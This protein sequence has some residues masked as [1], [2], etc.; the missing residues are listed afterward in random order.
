M[1]IRIC[2]LA[3]GSEG[4][5]LIAEFDDFRLLI[6]CGI[7]KKALWDSL[8]A[9]AVDPASLKGLLLTHEHID[10]CRGLLPVLKHTDCPVFAS[11]GSFEGLARHGFFERLPKD[12]F[13]LFKGGDTFPLGPLKVRTIP[14]SHDSLEPVAFRL[15]TEEFSFA[16]VTDLGCY[17][18]ALIQELRG[19]QAL[20]L[21][22][23]HNRRML[24]AGPYP[25]SL[26]QRIDGTKGHL[27]NED[28]GQLLKALYHPGLEQVLLAHLSKT[29]NYPPLALETVSEALRGIPE[30]NGRLRLSIAP[31]QGCSEIICQ[32]TQ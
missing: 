12:R 3:S 13:I 2:T 32:S 31:Y 11:R 17:D 21:E 1:K 15:D 26:K 19:L 22:A 10:H 27:S 9:L 5:A 20:V 18:E 23:N 6:D 4:N 29:N 14:L 24:E 8:G 28:C 30:A 7:S 25:Y 16:S